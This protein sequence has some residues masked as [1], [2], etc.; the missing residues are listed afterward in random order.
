MVHI[1]IEK[2][3]SHCAE[4]ILEHSTDIGLQAGTVEITKGR[5]IA[6]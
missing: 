2:L 1:K 4:E 6:A 5:E 3:M